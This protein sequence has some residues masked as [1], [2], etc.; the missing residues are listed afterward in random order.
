M[1]RSPLL[2]AAPLAAAL[3]LSACSDQPKRDDATAGE[4]VSDMDEAREEGGVKSDAVVIDNNAGPTVTADA[5]SAGQTG[6]AATEEST[7]QPQ[8]GG[9]SQ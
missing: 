5:D 8:G 3:L 7:A 1:K 4:A 6:Q 9:S 2:L